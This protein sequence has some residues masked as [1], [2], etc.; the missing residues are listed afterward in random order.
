M[1]D[2]EISLGKGLQFLVITLSVCVLIGIGGVLGVTWYKYEQ[3]ETNA[4]VMSID[5]HETVK[6]AVDTRDS[7]KEIKDEIDRIET[8]VD[9]N[10]DLDDNFLLLME[11]A[12]SD[13]ISRGDSSGLINAIT[14]K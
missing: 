9:D 5:S 14:R 13:A 1:A 6:I 4:D 7:R 8:I 11:S 10:G 3:S 12:R 2:H